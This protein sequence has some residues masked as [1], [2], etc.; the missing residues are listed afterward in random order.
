MVGCTLCESR[1]NTSTGAAKCLVW[2]YFAENGQVEFSTGR[3]EWGVTG[4]GGKVKSPRQKG[5]VGSQVGYAKKGLG[6][7]VVDN[8]DHAESSLM[9]KDT[10]SGLIIP[11]WFWRWDGTGTG[12][13]ALWC[14]PV[15]PCGCSQPPHPAYHLCRSSLSA[16]VRDIQKKRVLTL[17]MVSRSNTIMNISHYRVLIE[18]YFGSFAYQRGRNT[19]MFWAGCCLKP[20]LLWTNF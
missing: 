16:L 4:G 9:A 7:T 13:W 2:L 8:V 14:R 6:E 15:S 19:T 1:P 20:F 18:V 10:F 11:R 12:P 3:V 5:R 17:N